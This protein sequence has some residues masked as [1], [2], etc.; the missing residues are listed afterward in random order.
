VSILLATVHIWSTILGRIEYPLRR[1]GIA[2][3]ELSRGPVSEP[4]MGQALTA[5]VAQHK[6]N[7]EKC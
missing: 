7:N 6:K 1:R 3:R 5:E 4:I 2:V